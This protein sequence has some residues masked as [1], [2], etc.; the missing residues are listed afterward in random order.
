MSSVSDLEAKRAKLIKEI[1]A[2]ESKLDQDD[3]DPTLFRTKE[4]WKDMSKALEKAATKHQELVDEITPKLKAIEMEM[5]EL[6]LS[7]C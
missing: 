3:E 1:K 5:F 2:I 7:F 6:L 4:A